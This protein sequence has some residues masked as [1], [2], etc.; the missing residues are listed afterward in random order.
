MPSRRSMFWNPLMLSLWAY[1]PDVE[2]RDHPSPVAA[3]TGEPTYDCDGGYDAPTGDVDADAG[4]DAADA[5][6]PALDN[7]EAPAAA[8]GSASAE[9]R[10]LRPNGVRDGKTSDPDAGLGVL[11]ARQRRSADLAA[12]YKT[13]VD[14]VTREIGCKGLNV[15]ADELVQEIAANYVERG[16]VWDPAK[17]TFKTLITWTM[18]AELRNVARRYL[19]EKRVID[20]GVTERM[21]AAADASDREFAVGD[22]HAVPH[23]AAASSMGVVSEA[24]R[25]AAYAS[26]ANAVERIAAR[27]KLDTL[28]AVAETSVSLSAV[29]AKH[30]PDFVLDEG[31]KAASARQQ[32]AIGTVGQ[33]IAALA[34]SAVDRGDLLPNVRDPYIIVAADKAV[35]AAPDK[36]DA[37]AASAATVAAVR[38]E[39]LTTERLGLAKRRPASKAAAAAR[40]V[41]TS[42]PDA[43]G[44]AAAAPPTPRA[45]PRRVSRA[46]E[47][48]PTTQLALCFGEAPTAAPAPVERPARSMGAVTAPDCDGPGC[49]S[50]PSV[51]VVAPTRDLDIHRSSFTVPLIDA[52]ATH[53]E[54]AK[55][56]VAVPVE[57]PPVVRRR[58][59]ARRGDGA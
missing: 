11:G 14:V 31:I 10:K 13:L 42:S 57:M 23:S 58:V 4:A 27:R 54:D 15:D 52:D 12:H 34:A 49:D 9:P 43:D 47:V 33:A 30:H 29:M 20:R 55:W 6:P 36:I 32:R 21:I 22:L 45:L 5:A 56:R 50:E 51:F 18:R 35:A 8:D 17:A 37:D 3:T 24:S 38:V 16:K 7:T 39:H 46:V 19:A 28:A 53:E 48:A 2:G 44:P 25:S 59:P 40:P 26:E 1:A 41:F